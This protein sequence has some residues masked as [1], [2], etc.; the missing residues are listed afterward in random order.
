[1]IGTHLLRGNVDRFNIR[2]AGGYRATMTQLEQSP[3]EA[4]LRWPLIQKAIANGLGALTNE[5]EVGVFSY[6][7]ATYAYRK[8]TD[9]EIANAETEALTV[10]DQVEANMP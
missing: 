5:V 10:L 2:V 8:F 4:E 1:M 9:Q 7:D 3:W 6:A